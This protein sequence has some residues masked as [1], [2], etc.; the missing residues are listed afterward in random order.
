M[1]KEKEPCRRCNKPSERF[2]YGRCKDGKY[3][4]GMFCLECENYPEMLERKH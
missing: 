1:K 3:R 2:C 4:F